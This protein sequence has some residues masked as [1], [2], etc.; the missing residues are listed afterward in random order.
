MTRSYRVTPKSMYNSDRFKINFRYRITLQY[1]PNN[2]ANTTL[3]SDEVD[4]DPRVPGYVYNLLLLDGCGMDMDMR[5]DQNGDHSLTAED[6]AAWPG[7]NPDVSG[8]GQVTAF[9]LYKLLCGYRQRVA[10]PR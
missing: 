1:D 4:E 8:N 10:L 9:D 6:V 5:Y 7:D 3:E 2:S